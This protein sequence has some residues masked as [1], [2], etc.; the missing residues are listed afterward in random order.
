MTEHIGDRLKKTPLDALELGSGGLIRDLKKNP[1]L[2]EGLAGQLAVDALLSA[3]LT[4]AGRFPA[5]Q[6][7]ESRLGTRKRGFAEFLFRRPNRVSYAWAGAVCLGLGLM[8]LLAVNSGV[9]FF[10]NEHGAGLSSPAEN[11]TPTGETSGLSAGEGLGAIAA[12]EGQLVLLPEASIA[13]AGMELPPRIH[14]RNTAASSARL[15]LAGGEV[16]ELGP[17]TEA[18]VGRSL[19][20]HQVSLLRGEIRV[21]GQNVELSAAGATVRSSGASYWCAIVKTP[22]EKEALGLGGVKGQVILVR[23]LAGTA[24][25]SNASGRIGLVPGVVAWCAQGREPVELHGEM[26]KN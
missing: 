26:L 11:G 3:A 16:F 1:S 13:H 22:A 6:D 21:P 18:L 8:A 4:P 5:W 23:T 24:E 10:D 15:E 12:L 9:V 17:D 14:L 20:G 19:A 25:L 7:I 2:A